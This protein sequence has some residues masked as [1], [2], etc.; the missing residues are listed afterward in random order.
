[1]A[2]GSFYKDR[3]KSL[4]FAALHSPS[5]EVTLHLPGCFAGPDS[6]LGHQIHSLQSF[7]L[8]NKWQVLLNQVVYFFGFC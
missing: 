2:S 4:A 3:L 7:N 6:G 8:R 1:M 5:S